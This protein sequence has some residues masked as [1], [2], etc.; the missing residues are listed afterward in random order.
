VKIT[1]NRAPVLTLWA[2]VVAERMGFDSDTALSLG[3]A[4]AGMNAQS[5]GQ[6]LGIYRPGQNEDGT[7]L[8]KV[9]LGE[10]FWIEFCGRSVPAKQT[11]QGVRAVKKDQPVEPEKTRS[12]LESKFKESLAPAR[13]AMEEL[14]ASMDPKEI[15]EKAYGLYTRFRPEIPKGKAGW[16]A[17]GELDLDL[18]RDLAR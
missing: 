5:K 16:G 14:A 4:L 12:Y 7:P 13:E 3:R 17:K 8:P 15:G 10:E 18:I 9:G 11:P 2:T 6:M 1:I